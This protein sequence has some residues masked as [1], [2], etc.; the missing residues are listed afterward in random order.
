MREC[1]QPI[2]TKSAQAVINKAQSRNIQNMSRLHLYFIRR[3]PNWKKHS[4]TEVHKGVA[5]AD[6]SSAE[7]CWSYKHTVQAVSIS[8]CHANNGST[9]V[10]LSQEHTV[11]ATI[12]QCRHTTG[13]SSSSASCLRFDHVSSAACIHKLMCQQTDNV[14]FLSLDH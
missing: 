10:W 8:C 12:A 14:T 11:H 1:P 9:E 3:T 6:N 7:N 5:H 13:W 4:K 2:S